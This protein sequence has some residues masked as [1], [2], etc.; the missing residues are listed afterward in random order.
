MG[1]L[2]EAIANIAPYIYA[3]CGLLALFQLYRTW[4]V[5][6]ERRQAVFSLERDKAIDDLYRIFLSALLMLVVMGF[7]YFASTTLRE[8]M[9]AVESSST[10]S[11]PD[12]SST[13][14]NTS[15]SALIPTPTFTPEPPTPTPLP[16][17]IVVSTPVPDNQEEDT[18]PEQSDT[19]PNPLPVSPALCPDG[20]AVILSPGNGAVVSGQV[21][22]VGTAQHDRFSFYKLEFAASGANQNFNYFDGAE[23][24]VVGGLLGNLNSTA[25]ANG[26]YVI[27]V[28]VVDATGN[29]PQPCSVTVTVQN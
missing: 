2:V 27:R 5:R 15:L 24:P 18:Q 10:L 21:P 28:V 23:N 12:D 20:R 9:L 19:A 8:A 4:Q 7:T 17:R 1:F 14:P 11:S 26:A 6:A 22:I 25:M 29:Y 16:T 3:T 13:S